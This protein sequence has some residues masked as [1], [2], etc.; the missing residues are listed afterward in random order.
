[1]MPIFYKSVLSMM[2][3]TLPSRYLGPI[4]E[5]VIHSPYIIPQFTHPND[6]C[7]TKH[8]ALTQ[9]AKGISGQLDIGNLVKPDPNFGF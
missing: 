5:Y 4:V 7:L 6:S 8:R 9:K 2:P 3:F 1:M